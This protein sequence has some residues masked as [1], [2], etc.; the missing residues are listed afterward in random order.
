M[1]K[2]DIENL[3]AD[4]MGKWCMK[5]QALAALRRSKMSQSEMA[6]LTGRSTKTIQRFEHYDCTD[7]ELMY[8]YKQ[9]LNG[10]TD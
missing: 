6:F 2:A 3:K 4:F 9:L 10:N 7:P 5:V 1:Q 8:I